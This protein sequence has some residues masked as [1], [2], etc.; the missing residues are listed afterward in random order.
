MEAVQAL[1]IETDPWGNTSSTMGR[2]FRL[3]AEMQRHT[4]QP[5]HSWFI[6]MTLCSKEREIFLVF[7]NFLFYLCAKMSTRPAQEGNIDKSVAT[8]SWSNTKQTL[9]LLF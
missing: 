5:G 8:P 6:V 7:S 9:Y 4:H 2:V 1:V 3:M